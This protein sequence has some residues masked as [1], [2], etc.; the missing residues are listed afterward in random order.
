MY[1]MNFVKNINSNMTEELTK[2]SLNLYDL[3]AYVLD[4]IRISDQI[5]NLK[6]DLVLLD[7]SAEEAL[8]TIPNKTV[9]ITTKKKDI[10]YLR[11]KMT[12]NKAYILSI[13]EGGINLQ[14]ILIL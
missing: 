4:R 11:D 12:Y 13:I 14:E 5:E 6:K 9:V 10:D 7:A 1:V 2:L 8:N 3:E